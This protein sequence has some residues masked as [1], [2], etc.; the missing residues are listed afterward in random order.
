MTSF[1]IAPDDSENDYGTSLVRLN[2]LGHSHARLMRRIRIE[3]RSPKLPEVDIWRWFRPYNVDDYEKLFVQWRDFIHALK[4][5]G[6]QAERLPWTLGD[7]SVRHITRAGCISAAQA[8]QIAALH[9]LIIKPVLRRAEFFPLIG[10]AN[11]ADR[12]RTH[13]KAGSVVAFDRRLMEQMPKI[14][15]ALAHLDW[16]QD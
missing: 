15:E 16:K 11:V 8:A 10:F 9:E 14:E 3:I 6:V 13:A 5:A 12:V 1:R 4:D 2:N 7:L